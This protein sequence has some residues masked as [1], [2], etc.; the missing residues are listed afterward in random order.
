MGALESHFLELRAPA[1]VLPIY[2]VTPIREVTDPKKEKRE[3]DH[4]HELADR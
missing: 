2:P 3:W 4:S 1:V